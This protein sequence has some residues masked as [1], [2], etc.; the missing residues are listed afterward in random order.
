VRLVVSG[1]GTGGHSYPALAVARHVLSHVSDSQVMYVGSTGGPEAVAAE[2]A[3]LRFEGLQVAGVAGRSL[4]DAAR[5]VFM[6]LRAS[7]RCR[8]LLKEF[9]PDCVLGTGGYASAPACLAALTLRVPLVLHELNYEPGMVTRL[10]SRGAKAVAVGYEGTIPRLPKRV[11]AVV[12]GVPVRPEIEAIAGAEGRREAR[13]EAIAEWRLDGK[14][15]TLLVF[16][17]SQ[18]AEAL[19]EAVWRALGGIARRKDLQV[20]HLTGKRDFDLEERAAAERSLPEGGLVYRPVAYTERM[21]LAY[22][23]CDLALSR[24]GASTVAELMAAGVPAVLVPF[25]HATGAHQE[26]N[27]RALEETGAVM[28]VRQACGSA[29]EAA[30]AALNVLDDAAALD[31]MK[32]AACAAARPDGAKGIARLLAELT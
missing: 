16:G 25:P 19:N 13:N 17:G 8:R 4:V 10:F 30:G 7:K 32:E 31:L 11:R 23:V 26:K 29:D 14:R 22:A 6:F 24:A 3:G 20:L 5:A 27:A 9:R 18:G 15:N 1:G 2:S 28:V 21:D 12:T